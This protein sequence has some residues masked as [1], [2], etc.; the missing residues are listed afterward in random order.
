MPIVLG[1]ASSHAP[2]VDLKPENWEPYYS[3]R[4][5]RA[6]QP[7]SAALET[8]EVLHG[9]R[10]RVHKGF[11]TLRDKLAEAKLD[12]LIVIGG[13]QSEMFDRSN[14]PNIM[15]YYGDEAWGHSPAFGTEPSEEDIV[16][17]NLDKETS[18]QLLHRLVKQD[19][20][21]VAF[22]TELTNMS[23][24]RRGLPHAFTRPIPW[25]MPDAQTP[26]VILYENTYD[27]PSLS[28]E[29]CYELGQAL[30]R[31]F[32]NDPRRIGIYGS[33]GLSHDPAGPRAGWV[34]EELDQWFLQTIAE[35]RGKDTKSLYSFD[36]MTMRGG[37]GEIR[38]WITVAGA[39]E[40]LGSR[41]SVV[42]YIPVNHGVTGLS[43]AYWPEPTGVSTVEAS[44][45]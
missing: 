2:F 11:Y 3:S 37:T 17:L 6:P 14:V 20:F 19:E 41:A 12:L 34:D 5:S 15:V 16:R 22:S 40:S 27:P 42:D 43:W 35:G 38:A 39:M 28:A 29:R 18:R 13:D 33:G 4:G 8:E 32:A 10:D 45:R 1:L 36:S 30:T 21:D 23:S 25:I 7:Y 9:Y 31:A 24:R 26:V 44:A